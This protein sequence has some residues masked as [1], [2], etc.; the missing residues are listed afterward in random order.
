MSSTSFIPSVPNKCCFL[1]LVSKKRNDKKKA[2]KKMQIAKK[3]KTQ[4]VQVTKEAGT[5]SWN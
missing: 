4:H 5:I 2:S 1:F 3:K